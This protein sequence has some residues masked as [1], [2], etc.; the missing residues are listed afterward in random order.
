VLGAT[1]TLLVLLFTAA[2]VAK[3]AAL[4]VLP[5]FPAGF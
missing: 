4:S 5:P 2:V 3:T 1:V